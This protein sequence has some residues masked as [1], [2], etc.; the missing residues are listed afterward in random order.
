MFYNNMKSDNSLVD[1]Q[2]DTSSGLSINCHNCIHCKRSSV[3]VEY[4][5]C[6]KSGG[7]FCNL[8]HQFPENYE[9]ICLNYSAWS[10]R[11]KSILELIGEKIRKM[12]TDS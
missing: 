5:K 10:P 9:H 1:T 3:D 2:I 12:L 6:M 7:S 4:D 8:I 11:Q